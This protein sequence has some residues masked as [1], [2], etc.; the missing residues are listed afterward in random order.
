MR[1][2]RTLIRG[3]EMPALLRPLCC[4]IAVVFFCQGVRLLPA[5]AA[6]A[7]TTTTLSVTS[8]GDAVTTVAQG[9][10]VTLTAT[11]MAGSTPVTPGQVEFCDASAAVCSD[12]HLLGTAQLTGAGTATYN[13]LATAG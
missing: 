10:T 3:G 2:Q 9:K 13:F 7:P 8:G 6:P 4:F 1:L 11:V 12:I 5:W